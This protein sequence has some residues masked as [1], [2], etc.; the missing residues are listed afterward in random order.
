MTRTVTYSI[1]IDGGVVIDVNELARG[2]EA[3]TNHQGRRG[4]GINPWPLPWE[5]DQVR[6]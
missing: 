5:K 2:A 6:W 3:Y 4:A 1:A